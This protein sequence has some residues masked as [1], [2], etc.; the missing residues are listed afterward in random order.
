MINNSDVEDEDNEFSKNE[1][2]RGRKM[3]GE[4]ITQNAPTSI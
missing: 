3:K 4:Q 1:S 2:K